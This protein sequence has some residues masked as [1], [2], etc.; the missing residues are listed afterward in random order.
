MNAVRY[1]QS[2]SV[3][4]L[5]GSVLE[6]SLFAEKC[7]CSH[8]GYFSHSTLLS[9]ASETRY[10]LCNIF[11]VSH[12]FYTNSGIDIIKKVARDNVKLEFVS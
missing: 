3:V 8:R 12:N 2:S 5:I 7:N 4:H 9:T 11:Y 10:S 1:I 6:T